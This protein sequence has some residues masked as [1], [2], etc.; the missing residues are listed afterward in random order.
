[1]N[2][3]ASVLAFRDERAFFSPSTPAQLQL[4]LDQ[5]LASGDFPQR[6]ATLLKA[7]LAWPDEPDTHIALYKFYFVAAEYNKAEAAVWGAMRQAA[8][9]AGFDR[10]YRRLNNDSAAWHKKAGAERLYL[11]SLKALGVCRL[12]RGRVLAA[13]SVLKK[14]LELDTND[15]I[16]G[17]AYFTI[18]SSFFDEDD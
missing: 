14:L 7:R 12:R 5:A 3:S 9:L 16:G 13:Y 8:K 10:N 2:T 18:A 6:E 4:V 15:E 1:M 17:Y 11:F